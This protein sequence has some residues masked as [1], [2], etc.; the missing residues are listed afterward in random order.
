MATRAGAKP[1][2][3]AAF[4]RSLRRA[5]HMVGAG[6]FFALLLFFALALFSYTQTDPSASTAASG[7]DISNWMG[8]SGA[9]AADQAYFWFGLPALL[10][11]PLLWI[12]A[13]RLWTTMSFE[14][15]VMTIGSGRELMIAVSR[16]RC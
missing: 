15:S 6:V 8:A 13:R 9:W 16:S 5:T 7:S 4:R 12:S 3:R 10:L 11:L 14:T 1:D 2:W